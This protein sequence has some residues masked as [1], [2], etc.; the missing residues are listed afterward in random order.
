MD[1][2]YIKDIK[3]S[4]KHKAN[5]KI[6]CS[7]NNKKVTLYLQWSKL[8]VHGITIPEVSDDIQ[9]EIRDLFIKNYLWIHGWDENSYADYSSETLNKDFNFYI[10]VDRITETEGKYLKNNVISDYYL[11]KDMYPSFTDIIN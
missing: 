10:K 3:F 8:C 7:I 6:K 2:Q 11:H 1:Y 9:K 5:R 4:G